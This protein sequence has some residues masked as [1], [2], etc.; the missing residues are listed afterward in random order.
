MFESY[1]K[2]LEEDGHTCPAIVFDVK[3]QVAMA[4]TRKTLAESQ[5][6]R[7]K[8]P[9]NEEPSPE[10]LSLTEQFDVESIA[11]SV[12]GLPASNAQGNIRELLSQAMTLLS[13]QE[14]AE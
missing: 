1:A 11:R 7:D 6:P 10:W 5:A 2:V 13:P 8:E 9:D 14:P 4:M 12:R 3:R